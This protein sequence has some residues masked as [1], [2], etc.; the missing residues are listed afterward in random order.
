MIKHVFIA[1]AVA[2]ALL[3]GGCSEEE[4]R[5]SRAHQERIAAEQARQERLAAEHAADL[6]AE[7]QRRKDVHAAETARHNSNNRKMLGQVVAFLAAIGG[8]IAFAVHSMRRVAERH[9]E[10][11]TERHGMSLRSIENNPNLTPRDRVALYH[12]AFEAA[13]HGGTPLLGYNPDDEDER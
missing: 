5:E 4:R 1:V 7:T 13:N 6:A 10:E 12:V 3:L 8:V 9:L 11:R 2:G